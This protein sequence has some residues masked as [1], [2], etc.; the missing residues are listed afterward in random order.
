MYVFETFGYIL[1]L[2]S[3]FV[4]FVWC[5][6]YYNGTVNEKQGFSSSNF[7]ICDAFWQK[8][9]IAVEVVPCSRKKNNKNK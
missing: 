8:K 6:K 3:E 1:L 4:D 5:L 2:S 9:Y 7:A